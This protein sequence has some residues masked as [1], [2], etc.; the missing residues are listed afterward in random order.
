MCMLLLRT[1]SRQS[2][3][4]VTAQLLQLADLSYSRSHEDFAM[5]CLPVESKLNIL[6]VKIKQRDMQVNSLKTRLAHKN[7]ANYFAHPVNY[8]PA[9]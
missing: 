7:M 4:K 2:T 9:T 8:K 5:Y 3:T 1:E 6:K